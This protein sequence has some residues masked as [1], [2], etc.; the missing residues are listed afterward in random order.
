MAPPGPNLMIFG[1]RPLYKARNLKKKPEKVKT[2]LEPNDKQ[3]FLPFVFVDN[4][5]GPECAAVHDLPRHG[6]GSLDP[7][8]GHVEGDVEAGGECACS[9]T[10]PELTKEFRC[11]IRCL[12]HKI[13]DRVEKPK[14]DHVE[15]AVAADCGRDAL[16]CQKI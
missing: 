12:R 10:Y 11:W 1:I 13:F 6:L 7:T 4:P 16:G 15:E 14:V 8:L 2:I 9:E 5:D 3:L